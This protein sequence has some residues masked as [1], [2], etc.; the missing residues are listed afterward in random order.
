MSDDVP[1]PPGQPATSPEPAQAPPRPVDPWAVRPATAY[2]AGPPRATPA[3][4]GREPVAVAALVFGIVPLFAGVVGIVLGFVALARI[5]RSGRAGRRLAVIGL[6][7]G[8]A[9][10]L[11]SVA[12]AALGARYLVN[13]YIPHRDAAGQLTSET[14]LPTSQ[15]RVGDCIATLPTRGAATA[16]ARSCA[17]PHVAEVFARQELPTGPYPG[18]QETGGAALAVCRQA[19]PGYVGAPAGATGYSIYDR[20]P[21]EQSWQRGQHAVLCILYRSPERTVTGSARSAGPAA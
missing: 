13:R 18:V 7:L 12:A 10:L 19:L 11:V 21:S 8:T 3:Q 5:R 1:N 17:K 20:Y 14:H 2:G 16:A 9:W 6:A 4:E 15:L